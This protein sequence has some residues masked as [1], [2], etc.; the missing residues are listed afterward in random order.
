M[1]ALPSPL[2]TLKPPTIPESARPARREAAR[3]HGTLSATVGAQI[4][5]LRV[6]DGWSG[7][8]LAYHAE[9]SRSALS[10][11]ERGLCCP[12]LRTLER[13]AA[14]LDV[15][16]AALFVDA[17]NGL[18]AQSVERA[19]AA[20]MG[21]LSAVPRTRPAALTR[22]ATTAAGGEHQAAAGRVRPAG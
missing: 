4:Q 15:P 3:A 7:A 20:L 10:R 1:A 12:S 16:P 22:S 17:S 6:A 19:L 8:T 21:V 13:I 9:I 18:V 2:P 5:R 14:V 11:I